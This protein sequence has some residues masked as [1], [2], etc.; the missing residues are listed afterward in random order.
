MKGVTP[1]VTPRGEI[2]LITAGFFEAAVAG[3]VA[4]AD[5]IEI[6]LSKVSFM[7]ARGLS[8]LIGAYHR[9]GDNATALVIRDPSPTALLAITA[10][11]VDSLVDLHA[12]R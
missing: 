2:D 10:S 9:L 6:D 8:V 11:D 7:D 1:V 5:R 12:D 4:I 3:A